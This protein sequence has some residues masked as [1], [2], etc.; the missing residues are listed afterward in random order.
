MLSRSE[1]IMDQVQQ[2]LQALFGLVTGPE[3]RKQHSS[4]APRQ[5]S[6]H[7]GTPAAV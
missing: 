3:A 2:G 1:P 6:F 4:V 5:A 7:Y